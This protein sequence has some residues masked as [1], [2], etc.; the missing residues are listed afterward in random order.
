[1]VVA[2]APADG[3]Q[4]A[5]V[6]S[7]SECH[8]HLR[9]QGNVR[10]RV[11]DARVRVGALG[12][13]AFPRPNPNPRVSYPGGKKFRIQPPAAKATRGGKKFRIQPPAAKAA[14]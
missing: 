11:A 10:P 8:V 12:L 7:F 1:M 9:H 14:Q 4:S 3:F 6:C 5:V 2:V 13:T